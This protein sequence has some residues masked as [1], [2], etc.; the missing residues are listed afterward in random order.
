MLQ[1]MRCLILSLVFS[2]TVYVFS[3]VMST[4]DSIVYEVVESVVSS[5][6]ECLII[7]AEV[8]KTTV[9]DRLSAVNRQLA[10]SESFEMTPERLNG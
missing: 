8:I 6:N 5:S 7:V 2:P 1:I 10:G 9:V 3:T 4:A